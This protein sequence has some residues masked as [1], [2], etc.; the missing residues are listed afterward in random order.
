[1]D[2]PTKL[3]DEKYN[4][5]KELSEKIKTKRP[6]EGEV[7]HKL[8]LHIEELYEYIDV[9]EAGGDDG[10]MDD[11]ALKRLGVDVPED[12]P[13]RSSSSRRRNNSVVFGGEPIRYDQWQ[14]PRTNLGY[15]DAFDDDDPPF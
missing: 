10:A 5:I 15:L 12:T 6:S 2:K 7:I 13:V 9:L 1:M 11:D 14:A 4:K 8:I 3:S